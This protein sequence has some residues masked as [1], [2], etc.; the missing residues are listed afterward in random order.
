[1][2]LLAKV[3][4]FFGSHSFGLF[5]INLSKIFTLDFRLLFLIVIVY[6][7]IIINFYL[8]IVYR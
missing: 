7:I 6:I 5:M 4:V 3:I 8:F 2:I 1:M